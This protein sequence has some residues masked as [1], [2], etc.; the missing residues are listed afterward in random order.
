DAGAESRGLA[1]MDQH[2]AM[3]DLSV[4]DG[5]ERGVLDDHVFAGLGR[6]L[7]LGR[8]LLRGGQSHGN[9][10]QNQKRETRNEKPYPLSLGACSLSRFGGVRAARRNPERS[11]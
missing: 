7:I 11:R 4:S 6:R 1:G 2:A 5:H 9:Y 10:H 8:L 3:L